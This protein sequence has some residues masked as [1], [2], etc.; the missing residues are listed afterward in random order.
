M[1]FT[2]LGT[3]TSHGVPVI[4]CECKVCKS[5]N[6]KD[7]RFRCSAHILSQNGTSVIIDLSPEFRLQAVR[8]KIKE[9]DAILI[10]HSHAD[11]LHGIDDIRIFSCE[12]SPFVRNP[13]A[14]E[15]VK[16]PLPLFTNQNTADDLKYKFSYFFKPVKQGSGR[17]KIDLQVATQTFSLKDLQ[18]TP[19]PLKHGM[20]ETCGWIIT[21]NKKSIAYLTDCNFISE[22]SYKIIQKFS[23][24]YLVIDGLQEREHSTHFNFIQAMQAADRIGAKF[25]Y[26]THLT[27][28]HSHKDVQQFMNK[29]LCEFQNLTQIVKNG[30]FIKPA[31]DNLTISI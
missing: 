7:K 6:K 16:P 31:Y 25:T 21:E 28:K 20:L 14:N 8:S 4:G 18:I 1:K 24:E 15:Y 12:P 17:A 29:H 26:F 5:R 30:G 27:H 3:G 10:T 11:H 22:E 19:V 9:V 23:P 13:N 2:F